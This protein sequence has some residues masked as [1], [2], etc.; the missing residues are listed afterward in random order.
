[1]SP[2]AELSPEQ[3]KLRLQGIGASEI[4]AV[5]G[6]D[7]WR[8]ALDVFLDKT[9]QAEPIPENRFQ[10]WG[11]RLEAVIAD[12]YG[13]RHP[14]VELVA[15]GTLVG[16]ESWMLA[17]PD[18]LVLSESGERW[19][20]ECKARGLRMEDEWGDEGTDQVPVYVAAQCHW[21]MMVTGLTRWDVA[22]LINGNDFRTYTLIADAAV[23][24]RMR[25]SGRRFWIDHVQ[26]NVHPPFGGD[27]GPHRWLQRVYPTHTNEM[28]AA[29][30]EVG[31]WA[32][33]LQVHRAA[34][35]RHQDDAS[36]LEAQIKEFIA[37]R[38]GVEGPFGKI[39]WRHL[40]AAE[41]AAFTRKAHR[42]L[43]C[44]F[45]NKATD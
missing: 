21:S 13:E 29:T 6:V 42:R 44:Q 23:H 20:L 17:T 15:P 22:V 16:E 36:K 12:E 38:L 41:V 43:L 37:D 9:E 33:L 7:P 40:D 24:E 11:K 39:T 18:R 3:R 26:A 14:Q 34:I 1:V 10:R 27:S 5:L 35:K 19:G 2:L 31:E 30:P 4:A 25:E 32:T 8:T 45:A 28:V